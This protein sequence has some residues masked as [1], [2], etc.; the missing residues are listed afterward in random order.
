[1][2]YIKNIK[3]EVLRSLNFQNDGFNPAEGKEGL[4]KKR[5]K[6][7]ANCFAPVLKIY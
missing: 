6:T 5:A 3:N 2:R 4:L 1:M 7:G